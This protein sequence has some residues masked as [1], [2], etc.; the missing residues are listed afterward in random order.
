MSLN[1][2]EPLT[3]N[4]Y[5][6][7][8]MKVKAIL[9][10]KKLFKAVIEKPEP[11]EAA[12]MLIYE[13]QND[14][15]FAIIIL[16]LSSEV[17]AM[18]TAETSAKKI[19]LELE[20]IH[21]GNREDRIIDIG[22]ELRGI[23]MGE[24]EKVSEYIMRVKGIASRSA[25]MG[26]VVSEREIVFHLVRGLNNRMADVATVLRSQ[27]SATLNEIQQTLREEET[28]MDKSR[29]VMSG[30]DQVYKTR[31]KFPRNRRRCF[32][33]N[34]DNHIARDC[35]FNRRENSQP[36]Y[37]PKTRNM[38]RRENQ[39]TNYAN[40]DKE[41]DDI[42]KAFWS[43]SHILNKEVDTF[44]FNEWMLDSGCT[45]HMTPRRDWMSEIEPYQGEIILAENGRS[46]EAKAKGNV[47]VT[48]DGDNGSR[49]DIKISDVLYVPSLRNNLLSIRKLIGHGYEIV[50]NRNG[51]QIY[52]NKDLLIAEAYE[53]DRMFVL[54]TSLCTKPKQILQKCFKANGK[55]EK[56]LWHRRLGHLNNNSLEQLKNDKMV[57]NLVFRSEKLSMC[58][59][60]IMGKITQKSYGELSLTRLKPLELISMDLCGPMPVDSKGGAR[61]MFVMV[62][63]FTRR[64]FVYLIKSKSEAF[65]CFVRFKK[66]S[67]NVLNLKIKSVR[68]DNGGEFINRRFE[69]LFESEGIEHQQTV[70]YS[71]QSN[72]IAERMNRTLLD[73]ARTMLI[74][75]ELPIEFW[76]EAI[77]TAAY[78]KNV[79]P[80]ND[81]I[82]KTPLERWSGR[83][84]SVKFF[85]V[86]GCLAYF[87]IP[88]NHRNKL[89]P[90]ADKGIF[91][92]Y[93]LRRQAYRIYKP[94]DDKIIEVRTARFDETI[95]GS[96]LLKSNDSGVSNVG[97]L[98]Y[99]VDTTTDV[100]VKLRIAV[101]RCEGNQ[102]ED[103]LQSDRPRVV[104]RR[105]GDT[106]EVMKRR[107]LQELRRREDQ[108]L[109]Q[110]VRRS[111][112]VR[113][114]DE[115]N[116]TEDVKYVP[117][118]YGEAMNSSYNETWIE[119]MK[120]EIQSLQV[121]N[122][123]ELVPRTKDMKI[124]R[125]KWVFKVKMKTDSQ[126]AFDWVR[127]DGA[128]RWRTK[129]I[130]RKFH[131]IKDEIRLGN[132]MI[133][134][135]PTQEM[136]ADVLTKNLGCEKLDKCRKQLNIGVS[137]Q[138]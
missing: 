93:S 117:K 120:N 13:E 105:K 113:A 26:Q 133:R 4:N 63:T 20:K 65:D 94:D 33:C 82:K 72:G 116:I 50:F 22:L 67:E 39:S 31:E 75:A 86:F 97:E 41:E 16:T 19:W 138:L 46:V 27:R 132:F 61:Y 53:K 83:V 76:G 84:P 108:L 11:K 136:E 73:K 36:N 128:T 5:Q 91:M 34:K 74:D 28:R 103:V 79:S 56:E 6:M 24:S 2:I 114:R 106:N 71:P 66:C 47:K 110:G 37:L 30:V 17:A 54:N 100:N 58:E 88:K 102:E 89:E 43:R 42:G 64:V 134:Y 52:D 90:K 25:T 92:G 96:I 119:A 32:T 107:H 80:K 8:Q 7:W 137:G 3:G 35:Y 12:E 81:G 59:P 14:E 57:R 130:N 38:Q 104:G 112:R 77:M 122:V 127:R 68:T 51:A 115:V 95:K 118:S 85:R 87:H 101:P 29:R 121:N 124:I 135:V 1:R 23:Q 62:D 55:N 125:S 21:T 69:E 15:A 131:F 40:H 129:H 126:S 45:T 123:W 70:P 98:K 44:E 60:C 49:R 48:I 99:R 18:F 78:L 109:E 111:E 9:K 10:S